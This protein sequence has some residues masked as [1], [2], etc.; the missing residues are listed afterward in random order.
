MTQST[1]DALCFLSSN[2]ANARRCLAR[3]GQ[4]FLRKLRART[5]S[6]LFPDGAYGGGEPLGW[7]INVAQERFGK[8]GGGFCFVVTDDGRASLDEV[9][10]LIDVGSARQNPD[11]G[12]DFPRLLDDAEADF[13]LGNGD[14]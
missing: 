10:M 5:G 8:R 3:S 9:I 1:R 12:G 13:R 14:D 2:I 7:R 6:Q 11:H 4:R